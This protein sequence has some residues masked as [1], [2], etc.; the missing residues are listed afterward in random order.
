[1]LTV[2]YCRAT[3]ESTRA[4]PRN[5]FALLAM[6]IAVGLPLH[7]NLVINP[8][9]NDATFTAAG[10]NPTDV[11]NGFAMAAQVFQNVYTD[12]VHVNITVQAGNTG[13]G[14]SSTNLI[15]FLTYT[16]MRNALIADNTAHPSAD[17]NT[18][19]ASLPVA[20][21]TGGGSFVAAR[22][23]AKALAL[24]PDDLLTDGI[25]TFSNAQQYTWNNSAAAGKFDFVGVAEHEI[26][27]IMG[28]IGILGQNFGSGASYGADDLFRYTAPGVRSLN[29]TDTNV[30]LSINGGT[31]NLMG[32]NPPNGGDL[33][34]YVG[35][36]ATD[37]FNAFTGSNQAHSF[38]SVDRTNMDIIGWDTATAVPEPTSV[39]LLGSVLALLA[40]RARRRTGSPRG[41]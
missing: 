16:Q 24:L 8:T 13:L 41:L 5:L 1:M 25:F 15:G 12:P 23:Q 3:N 22:A 27:E 17:G 37:P 7:A 31:T 11:H 10:F 30:Y 26:S 35:S 36:S 18:S 38:S 34:D 19:V 28:R 9:F 20:D 2:N 4:L 33:S 40:V 6:G 39:A 14:A 32:F 29:Q 21:P